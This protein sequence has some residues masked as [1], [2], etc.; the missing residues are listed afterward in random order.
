MSAPR[1]AIPV[2]AALALALAPGAAPAAVPV[3][4]YPFR[5]PGLT[6][7]QRSDLHAVLEAGLV[8]AARRGTVNPRS[9]LL[10]PS[11]C[12]ELPAPACLAAAARDGLVLAGRGEIKAGVVL[13]TAAL[14]DGRG[15]RT[16]EVRFVV[17]LVIQNMRPVGEALAELEVEIEPDGTVAGDAKPLPARDPHGPK[18][19]A[20]VAAPSSDS[21]PPPPAPPRDPPP[22]RPP[23]PFIPLPPPPKLAAPKAAPAKAAPVKMALA[24]VPAPAPR[25]WKRTAGPWLTGVG[26]ALLA[27][28]AAVGYVNRGLARDLEAKHAGG[29]LTAADRASFDRVDRYNV[30]STALFAAGG[31]AAAGGAF[32]WITAPAA[33]GQPAM[34]GAG[35]RF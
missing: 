9:P 14:W 33:P 3:A 30:L 15:A 27:G 8:S 25:L 10:L 34:A 23:I 16:R 28:G 20:V 22:E 26:T 5:V 18:V 21:R 29:T 13:I 31:A 24:P 12:G 11:T 7:T 35:G 17:D 1:L 32:I 6:A 4:L 2:L 19:P